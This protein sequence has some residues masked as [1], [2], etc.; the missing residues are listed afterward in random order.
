MSLAVAY[1]RTNDGMNAPQVSVEVDLSHGLPGFSIVGLPEAAVRESKDRVRSAIINSGFDFP[2]NR[3]TVNLAPADHP[4]QGG[5][6]DLPIA[7][8]I[9]AASRQL[10]QAALKEYEFIGELALSGELRA[11][12]AVL[13]TAFAAHHQG[14]AI[15]LPQENAGEAGIIENALVLPCQHLKDVVAHLN[16]QQPISYFKRTNGAAPERHYDVD[17][18]D[19]KGQFQAKRALE[20]AAAGGHHLLMVGPPGTGKTMLASRLVTILPEMTE[21]EALESASI[22]S[23]SNQGFDPDAWLKRPFRE[24]HHTSSAVALVGGGAKVLPGEISLA[25]HGVLFLDEL[26]EFKGATLEVLREPLETGRI[27]LSRAARQASYP[28]QFQLI[29]AMNPCPQGLDCDL[30]EK[31]QCTVERQ[32]RYR[33]RL[34]A[35]FLDRIDLQIHV[36]RMTHDELSC[37]DTAESSCQVRARVCAARERQQQRQQ[38]TN[39]TL[40]PK[41]VEAHCRLSAADSALLGQ[42]MESFKLSARACHRILKVARTIADLDDSEEIA[43]PHLSEAVSYRALDRKLSV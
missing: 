23:V 11:V 26:T 3:I 43:T 6:F 17:L 30:E 16:H 9:L 2:N 27:V 41:A 42:V 15:L 39:H 21:Q 10:E 14:R 25:H 28:A 38:Q 24:P 4:K 12:R 37:S 1:T 7:V 5:R 18:S 8:G 33:Q 40:T 20:I 22:A 35:P 13:P 19:V 29:A 32:R 36:P 31:C 34:S